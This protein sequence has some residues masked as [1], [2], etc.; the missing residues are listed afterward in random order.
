MGN[1]IKE[2]DQALQV[3]DDILP[4]VFSALTPFFPAVGAF[5]K[6]MPLLK[7]AITGVDTVAQATSHPLNLAMSEVSDH[8]TPGA[9]NS[10]S[11]SGAGKG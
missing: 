7:V 6:F 9:P 1:T 10:P 11:L 5:A 4:I 2:V 8:L 3:A